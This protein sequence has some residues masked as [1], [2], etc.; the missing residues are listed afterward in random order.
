MRNTFVG[1][2]AS[3]SKTSTIV[4]VAAANL[5]LELPGCIQVAHVTPFTAHVGRRWNRLELW[6]M[7]W[8]VKV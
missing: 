7:K 8:D 6:I 3:T 2:S 5:P 4:Q 1:A